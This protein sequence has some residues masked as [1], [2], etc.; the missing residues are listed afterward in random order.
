MNSK[1]AQ[2]WIGIGILALALPIAAAAQEAVAR[3][4]VNLRAG[5]SGDYPVVARLGPGQ[6]FEVLGCISGY[7]WCDVVLPDGLRGWVYSGAI[8]YVYEDRRFP[9]ATYGAT[10][11]VPIIGFTIGNYWADHYRDRPWYREPRWWH[12]RPPPPVA[13]WRPV[14]PPRPNWQPRPWNDR[15]SGYRPRPG[16]G[17]QPHPD[18]GFR[19]QPGWQPPPGQR[20]PP[21]HGFRP[22][23]PD[24]D[25][26]PPQP[27]QDVRPPRGDPGVRPPQH[28]QPPGI[29]PGARPPQMHPGQAA[30][31]PQAPG[32]APGP[33]PAMPGADLRQ[34][35]LDRINRPPSNDRP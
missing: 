1:L 28:A 29:Q 24:R 32:P 18:P 31:R 19:P 9:L 23:R 27:G 26:R 34:R 17:Y 2:R 3:N 20:P 7:S 30:G 15:D 8:D 13:G 6:P 33:A 5:P 22:P 21:E 16:P 12:G 10:I 11:G 35:Q 4:T 25:V 14:P